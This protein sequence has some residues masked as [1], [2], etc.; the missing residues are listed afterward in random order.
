MPIILVNIIYT[1]IIIV[2]CQYLTIEMVQILV[3]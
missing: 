2:G 3:T 1:Y